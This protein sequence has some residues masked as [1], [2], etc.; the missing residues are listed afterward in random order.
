MKKK[1]ILLGLLVASSIIGFASCGSKSKKKNKESNSQSIVETSNDNSNVSLESSDVYIPSESL[2]NESN[3]ESSDVYIP[4]ESLSSES[5][6]ESSDTQYVKFNINYNYPTYGV[7]TYDVEINKDFKLPELELDDYY[8]EGYSTTRNGSVEYYANYNYSVLEEDVTLYAIWEEKII[9]VNFNC[10]IG[11]QNFDSSVEVKKSGYA[12]APSIDLNSYGYTLLGW[13][14]DEFD[15]SDMSEFN[16]DFR[17][18]VSIKANELLTTDN[19][20]TLNAV[21]VPAGHSFGSTELNEVTLEENGYNEFK[22]IKTGHDETYYEN[23]MSSTIFATYVDGEFF[24]N[25]R[26]T[27]FTS[28]ILQ[29][30]IY[31]GD[32]V[33]CIKADGTRINTVVTGI[34]Y[35]TKAVNE[36]H[37]GQS[38]GFMLQGVEKDDLDYGDLIVLKGKGVTANKLYL[39]IYYYTKDEGGRHTPL[40]LN[41]SINI[42]YGGYDHTVKIE[43][44]IDDDDNELELLMPGSYARILVS[45]ETPLAIWQG[46]IGKLRIEGRI[47]A[48]Y[49][50]IER[51]VLD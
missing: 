47:V 45:S 3:S 22:C 32:E 11:T 29:G 38:V 5:N 24:I 48:D 31:V 20:A 15:P 34:S 51:V 36:A 6:S 14:F 25:G 35:D 21:F 19:V 30:D 42:N 16:V 28:T 33:E 17:P 10:S 37:A 39:D 50:V 41:N 8:L 7:K 27:V 44:I 9:T 23:V 12:L 4:S 26:G 18:N 43:K 13:T 40:L 46:S 2:S 49:N 1:S